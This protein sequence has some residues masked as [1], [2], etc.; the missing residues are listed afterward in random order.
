MKP[1]TEIPHLSLSLILIMAV[2]FFLIEIAESLLLPMIKGISDRNLLFID[3]LIPTIIIAPFMFWLLTSRSRFEIALKES[4]KRYR[5]LFENSPDAI[6]LADPETGI[7]IGANSKASELTAR[8]HEEI[9]GMHQAQL[10]PPRNDEY[11]RG[12]FKEHVINT[13][14]KENIRPI[15]NFVLRPDG[16]EVPVEVLAEMVT[17]K[18][19][20]VM[21]GVFRDI[22]ERKK[23]EKEKER[24]LVVS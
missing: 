19:R 3:A 18:G 12:G 2:A 20:Q 7:I 9:I 13:K 11:S 14:Q 5:T 21:Q 23:M 6:V 16:T 1:K 10:H 22:T 15:E 4:E 17:I 24:C 8:P